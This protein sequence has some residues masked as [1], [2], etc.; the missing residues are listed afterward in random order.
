VACTG[1][2]RDSKNPSGG[3]LRVDLPSLLAAART[4]HLNH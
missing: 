2:V 3:L 1:A 4:G